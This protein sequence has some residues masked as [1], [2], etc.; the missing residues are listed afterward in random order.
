M[1]FSNCASFLSVFVEVRDIY[2]VGFSL[3]SANLYEPTTP[4]PSGEVSQGRTAGKG[5]HVALAAVQL[6]ALLTAPNTFFQFPSSPL[7]AVHSFTYQ[8]R[9]MCNELSTHYQK[10]IAIVPIKWDQP[11][12]GYLYV[13][14]Y[15]TILWETDG[16]SLSWYLPSP[17]VQ[18][19]SLSVSPSPKWISQNQQRS[20]FHWWCCPAI[21][22]LFVLTML[23]LS[24]QQHSDHAGNPSRMV[25]HRHCTACFLHWQTVWCEIIPSVN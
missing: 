12:L 17:S 13:R 16:S 20:I 1:S 25:E 19:W 24:R 5:G 11:I 18:L 3:P 8:S 4:P 14:F 22:L 10:I 9:Q 6:A 23:F 7:S 15:I 2:E 21:L